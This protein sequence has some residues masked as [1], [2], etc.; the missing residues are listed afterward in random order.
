MTFISVRVK[1]SQEIIF[2]FPTFNEI[3]KNMKKE[4]NS[5]KKNYCLVKIYKVVQKKNLVFFCV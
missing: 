3:N 5:T 1:L 2:L 4:M